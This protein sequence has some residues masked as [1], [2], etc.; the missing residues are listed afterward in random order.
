MRILSLEEIEAIEA[1]EHYPDMNVV[2]SAEMTKLVYT[3]REYHRLRKEAKTMATR[4]QILTGRM[5]ACNEESGK[6]ELIDEAQAFC[7]E[8]QEALEAIEKEMG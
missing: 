3:A 4:L 6:H 2:L 5:R 8:A 1:R 7:D